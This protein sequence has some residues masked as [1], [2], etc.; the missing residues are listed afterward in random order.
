MLFEKWGGGLKEYNT[1]INLSKAHYIS[2]E[3]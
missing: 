1:G 2:M 3:V